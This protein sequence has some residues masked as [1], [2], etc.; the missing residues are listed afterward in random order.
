MRLLRFKANKEISDSELMEGIQ[1]GNESFLELLYDRC[2]TSIQHFVINNQGSQDEAEDIEVKNPDE[3][4][5]DDI[6]LDD[7]EDESDI[8]SNEDDNISE[9]D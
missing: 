3:N 7:S 4:N 1:M 9:Y 5:V 6:E 8:M 2:R